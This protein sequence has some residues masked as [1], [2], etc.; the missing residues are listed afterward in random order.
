MARAKG[1]SD[2]RSK[3][4]TTTTSPASSSPSARRNG[5]CNATQSSLWARYRGRSH[6]IAPTTGPCFGAT[7]LINA[8][9][10][11]QLPTMPI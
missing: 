11:F 5:T 1:V 8:R 6:A 9:L 10:R 4:I 7:G 3:P 2:I